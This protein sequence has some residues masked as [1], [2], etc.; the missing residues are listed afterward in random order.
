MEGSSL[1]T[2]FT[3][4]TFILLVYGDNIADGAVR[5]PPIPPPMLNQFEFSF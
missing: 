3:L 5:H 4:S 1:L 2:S